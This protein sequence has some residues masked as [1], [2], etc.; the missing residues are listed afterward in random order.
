MNS[1]TSTPPPCI[2]CGKPAGSEEHII[3]N[4]ILRALDIRRES[5]RFIYQTET[6]SSIAG[7]KEYHQVVTRD[8][9]LKCNNEWMSRLDNK[10]KCFQPLISNGYA[11]LHATVMADALAGDTTWLAKWMLKTAI[12]TDAGAPAA[13]HV[14][15]KIAADLYNDI[16][17]SHILVSAGYLNEPMTG[18]MFSPT[19]FRKG[20]ERPQKCIQDLAFRFTIQLNHLALN[21]TRFPGLEPLH[22]KRNGR[23]PLPCFPKMPDPAAC[24][25]R[26][27]NIVEFNNAM[28]CS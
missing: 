27:K 2:F 11:K 18:V 4:W 10:L 3:A 14:P 23:E 19:I 8:V 5:V 25:F 22:M 28:T 13:N 21:L 6:T 7:A 1:P 12:T 9:C 17:P 26:F 24:D 15:A 16:L 20:K